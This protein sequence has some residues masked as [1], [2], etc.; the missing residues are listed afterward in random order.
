MYNECDSLTPRH[1]YIAKTISITTVIQT[2]LQ[3]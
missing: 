3:M 1:C 2:D